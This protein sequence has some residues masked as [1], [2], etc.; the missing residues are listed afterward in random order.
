[1]KIKGL[2]HWQVVNIGLMLYDVLAVNASYF[3]AL[4]V[5]FDCRFSMIPD[6]YMEAFLK[7]API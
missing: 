1:M 2:R 6:Y 4:W 3:L 5:R 7:F